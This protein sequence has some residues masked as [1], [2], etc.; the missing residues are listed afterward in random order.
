MRGSILLLLLHASTAWTWRT[1]RSLP[2]GVV[3]MSFAS[4]LAG[5]V[6]QEGRNGFCC[7]HIRPHLEATGAEEILKS[8]R[9]IGQGLKLRPTE[10]FLWY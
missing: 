8:A 2:V 4:M 5:A 1:L 3:N 10:K 6:N 9:L 7:A